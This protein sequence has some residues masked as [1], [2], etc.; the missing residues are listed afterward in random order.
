M[1][2]PDK[3]SKWLEHEKLLPLQLITL[4]AVYLPFCA[5]ITTLSSD[6]D[7]QKNPVFGTITY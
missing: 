7:S 2:L 3:I 6:Y 5:C 4:G 1:T